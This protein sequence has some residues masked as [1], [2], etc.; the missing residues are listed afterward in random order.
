MKLVTIWVVAPKTLVGRLSE[1]NPGGQIVKLFQ[2]PP[3]YVD[4]PPSLPALKPTEMVLLPPVER[5]LV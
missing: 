1:L 3:G 2:F 4:P 5:V